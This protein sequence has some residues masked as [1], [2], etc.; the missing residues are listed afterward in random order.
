VTFTGKVLPKTADDFAMSFLQ[1]ALAIVVYVYTTA[2]V[3][4]A[5]AV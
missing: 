5:Q 1:G 4:G 2:N 3:R